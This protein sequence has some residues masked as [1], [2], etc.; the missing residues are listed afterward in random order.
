MDEDRPLQVPQSRTGLEPRTL[1]ERDPQPRVRGEGIG[2]PPT[3]IERGH[4]QLAQPFPKRVVPHQALDL[5][6][7]FGVAPKRDLGSETVLGRREAQ[8]LQAGCLGSGERFARELGQSRPSPQRIR[9]AEHVT[10]AAVVACRSRR[11]PL[12]DERLEPPQVESFRRDAQ[13][14]ARRDGV[15]YPDT[16]P[17]PLAEPG[18]DS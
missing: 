7:G 5:R 14:I 15:K 17:R 3:P 13:D 6:H 16:R 12:S 2:L 11:P 4:Q 1:D 18:A 10:R 8:L 9:L